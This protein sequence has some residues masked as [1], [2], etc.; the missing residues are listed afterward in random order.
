MDNWAWLS[1]SRRTGLVRTDDRGLRKETEIDR[2][3][4]GAVTHS[5][6]GGSQTTLSHFLV[7]GYR[8]ACRNS[9]ATLLVHGRR[10][11]DS[12]GSS[13]RAFTRRKTARSDPSP[14]SAV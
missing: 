3:R 10:V 6:P 2:P 7:N 11:L 12:H 4:R 14:R 13:R 9:A 1:P 8:G 5:L